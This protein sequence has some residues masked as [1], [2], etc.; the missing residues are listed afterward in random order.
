MNAPCVGLRLSLCEEEPSTTRPSIA[1]VGQRQASSLKSQKPPGHIDLGGS[2]V[3]PSLRNANF[4]LNPLHALPERL[5]R[6]VMRR[7][8]AYQHGHGG[9]DVAYIFMRGG[10]LLHPVFE[11]ALHVVHPFI[12][13]AQAFVHLV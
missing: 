5:N 11:N 3:Y 7:A 10:Q 2:W 6:C 4:S 9:A 1:A 13:L 8:I 12:H